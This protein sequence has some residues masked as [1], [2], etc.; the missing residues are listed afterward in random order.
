MQQ[1]VVWLFQCTHANC[2][3]RSE[4]L[5]AVVISLQNAESIDEKRLAYNRGQ[6]TVVTDRLRVTLACAE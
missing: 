2:K 5:T 6:P 4:L 1:C 3:R